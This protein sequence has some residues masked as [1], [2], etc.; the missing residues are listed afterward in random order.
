MMGVALIWY[1]RI[2]VI[3]WNYFQV[4]IHYTLEGQ[5]QVI[6]TLSAN[7]A[8][9]EFIYRELPGQPKSN[10]YGITVGYT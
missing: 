6:A 9:L 4:K 8:A 2:I 7:V 5:S 3:I 1:T 10:Y